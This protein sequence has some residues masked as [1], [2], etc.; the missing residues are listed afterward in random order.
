MKKLTQEDFIKKTFNVYNNEYTVIGNYIN[1]NTKI[2]IKHNKCG[3]IWEPRPYN[4]LAKKSKCP[5]CAGNKKLT[6]EEFL[7]KVKLVDNNEYEVLEEIKNVDTYCK[8]KHKTCGTI[9]Q[10]TPKCF[11]IGC[12]RCPVCKPGKTNKLNKKVLLK[13][14]KDLG[15][16]EYELMSEYID[17]DTPV[18]MKHKLCNTI[19]KVSINNF[20]RGERCPVCKK[21]KSK[22]ETKIKN[23]L[24]R[25]HIK[26]IQEKRFKDC[27]Y[28]HTLPFDFYLEDLNICI[29]YDGEQHYNRAF[30]KDEDD[31][32]IQH[33]RDNIKNEYC[34]KNNINLIRIPYWKFNEIDLILER[35]I[36]NE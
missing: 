31:L 7:E 30:F 8:F 17:I 32:K 25:H 10:Q 18:D 2:K 29:E 11:F 26:F 19:Y 14:I 36:I 27:K 5:Y 34:K 21:I 23:Y 22:G 12:S 16:N 9:F 13:R 15:N 33:I 6:Q 35:R 4:F 28:K 24:K 1:S 20:S 3:N